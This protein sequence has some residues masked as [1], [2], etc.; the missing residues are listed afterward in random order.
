MEMNE[1]VV[2][3]L[4]GSKCEKHTETVIA[5]LTSAEWE[6]EMF[7]NP[8]NEARLVAVL[9]KPWSLKQYEVYNIDEQQARF[10]FPSA[11]TIAASLISQKLSFVVFL[12]TIPHAIYYSRDMGS[13]TTGVHAKPIFPESVQ[14]WAT[15]IDEVNSHVVNNEIKISPPNLPMSI[16][17]VNEVGVQS[18]FEYQVTHQFNAVFE[19]TG[20]MLKFGA[21]QESLNIAGEPDIVLVNNNG[22]VQSFVEIKTRWALDN[23]ISNSI[24]S[25]WENKGSLRN[26]ICQ[27]M[28]YLCHNRLKYGCLSSFERNWFLKRDKMDLFISEPISFDST[29]PTLYQAF[30]FLIAPNHLGNI[31]AYSSP[32]SSGSEY[33]AEDLNSSEEH[34]NKQHKHGK[35][36]KRDAGKLDS[37][38]RRHGSK[39]KST[40]KSCLPSGFSLNLLQERVGQGAC[41]PVY[42]CHFRG[43]D[44]AV[45]IC[46]VFNN[47]AGVENMKREIQIYQHLKDLQG[48]SIPEL[49]FFG[50]AWGFFFIA[51]TFI[52]GSHPDI[53]SESIQE[54][55]YA[56]LRELE[57]FN[58]VHGD[59]KNDNMILTPTGKLVLIDFSHAT[60][61]K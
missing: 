52:D 39:R 17:V 36:L 23:L 30:D 48:I 49:K 55:L 54:M 45:K 51:T 10:L 34:N 25:D 16:S 32:N 12:Q 26:I 24:V 11:V 20:M 13:F 56:R 46:D 18:H 40:V 47:K 3:A 5:V 2:E 29:V 6:V 28:G 22:E 37:V 4:K 1:Y 59:V 60:T 53:K 43:V 58:I 35:K 31:E 19:Q 44:L 7:S 50:E 9:E 41:G 38:K 27:V 8:N 42:K 21:H 33:S 57:D 15:F 61:S 14:P